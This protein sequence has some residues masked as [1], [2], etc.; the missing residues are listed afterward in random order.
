MKV[1][2]KNLDVRELLINYNKL[3]V[4]IFANYNKLSI[5]YLIIKV[6]D[7]MNTSM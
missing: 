1:D 5:I 7:K 6:K 4:P 2:N 3:C